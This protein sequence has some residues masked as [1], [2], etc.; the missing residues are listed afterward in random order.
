[1]TLD[2]IDF[3]WQALHVPR[4]L[5][6]RGIRLSQGVAATFRLDSWCWPLLACAGMCIA[7]RAGNAWLPIASVQF[8]LAA[9]AM[10]ATV[11]LAWSWSRDADAIRVGCTRAIAAAALCGLGALV[12]L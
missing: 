12:G 7:A 3:L 11:M 1:M 10:N 6:D 8:T 9:A 2:F 4:L 5:A